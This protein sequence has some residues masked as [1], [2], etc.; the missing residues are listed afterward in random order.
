MRRFICIIVR[1]LSWRECLDAC[2]LFELFVIIGVLGRME[3]YFEF[4]MFLLE[5]LNRKD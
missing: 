3:Y 4:Y 5:I 2:N 1:W